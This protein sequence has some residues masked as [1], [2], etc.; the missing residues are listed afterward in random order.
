MAW[1]AVDEDGTEWR[2][3]RKPK[4][5][6]WQNKYTKEKVGN[7]HWWATI[8]IGTF[9]DISNSEKLPKDSIAK[10]IGR[11]LTWNDEPVKYE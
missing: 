10:L 9:V 1:L 6:F 2:F 3:E 11:E 5:R 7:G 4:R 8:V